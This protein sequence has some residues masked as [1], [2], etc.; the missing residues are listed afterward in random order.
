MLEGSHGVQMKTWVVLGVVTVAVAIVASVAGINDLISIRA[1]RSFIDNNNSAPAAIPTATPAPNLASQTNRLLGLL[2]AYN[3]AND[4]AKEQAL[5][6]LVAQAQERK[7]AFVATINEQPA[8]AIQAALSSDVRSGL[9]SEAQVFVEEEVV[10]EGEYIHLISDDFDSGTSQVTHLIQQDV[11]TAIELIPT[12]ESNLPK[13]GSRMRLKGYKIEEVVVADTGSEDLIESSA[14]ASIIEAAPATRQALIL[15]FNFQNNTSQPFTPDAA[16]NYVFGETQS[17]KD[18]YEETSFNKITFAGK[19]RPDGDVTNWLTIPYDN[20][21]CGSNYYT[22]WTSAARSA[23]VEAG[24]DLAGY[25]HIIFS[26]P[27]ADCSFGGAAYTGGTYVWVPSAY[28]SWSYPVRTIVVSHEVGHNLGYRHANTYECTENG[29]RVTISSTCTSNPYRD[30]FDIMGSSTNRHPFHM[31]SFRKGHASFFDPVNMQEVTS[32]GTYTIV[33]IEQAS[34][35]TQSLRIRR[36]SS[37]Y[38]YMEFRQPFGYDNFGAS[39][40]AIHGI[41]IRL[42]ADYPALVETQL[43]DATP[44]TSSYNDAALAVGQ[45]FSDPLSGV[46][47]T[48]QSVDS[49]GATVSVNFNCT[50][51]D[52][53]VTISPLSQWSSAGQSLDYGITIRNNDG[54]GCPSSAFTLSTSVPAGWTFSGPTD[55]GLIAPG[56]SVIETL[57]VTSSS[58]ATEGLYQ[59]TENVANVSDASASASAAASYNI[60]PPDTTA[61]TITITEPADGASLSGNRTRISVEASD[62]SGIA[63]IS[64]AVNGEVVNTCTNTA[65]CSVNWSTRGLPNGTYIITATAQDIVVPTPNIGTAS[66]T[67][68]IGGGSDGGGSPGGGQGGGRGGPKNN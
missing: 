57:T 39:D 5:N 17:L 62:M 6:D 60:I 55:S 43:L 30:L 20:T 23:A 16:R 37:S 48:T 35:G 7:N 9:P 29:Q 19:L 40:P 44:Q 49:S 66:V 34:S 64:I 32:S 56:G 31:S 4:Q 14:P 26:F 50:H 33:P 46:T 42:G 36:N 38:F 51:V 12:S 59:F 27:A 11:D 2:R 63:S 52:P 15:L 24:W 3:N 67:T 58:A 45:T 53:T 54:P 13:P 21:G 10:L 68:T 1:S 22:T 25:D 47:V 61:P 65:N 18:Y 41:S 8:E 28:L